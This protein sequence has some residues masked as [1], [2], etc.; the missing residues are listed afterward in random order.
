MRP[1]PCPR[2][3]QAHEHRRAPAF[4]Y[5]RRLQRTVDRL[6]VV[7][8]EAADPGPAPAWVEV[9]RHCWL[10]PGGSDVAGAAPGHRGPL[11]DRRPPL[12]VGLVAAARAAGAAR[13]SGALLDHVGVLP[14]GAHGDGPVPPLR[15]LRQLPVASPTPARA[16]S[17][18]ASTA[19][20]SSPA[21][22]GPLRFQNPEWLWAYKGVKWAGRHR[23]WRRVH[24]GLLGIAGRRPGGPRPRPPSSASSHHWKRRRTPVSPPPPPRT[25]AEVDRGPPHRPQRLPRLPR[26]LPERACPGMS[27]GWCSA[28][29]RPRQALPPRREQFFS[30]VP[31]QVDRAAAS[32]SGGL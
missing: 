15:R 5:D 12:R 6:P 10:R 4:T 1:L 30:A 29:E 16:R 11:H 13:P 22:G 23:G 7:H 2:R 14:G 20:C 32:G 17:P 31:L 28:F 19:R 18:G 27:Y 25:L 24:A 26:R 3:R 8:L 9:A 21:H